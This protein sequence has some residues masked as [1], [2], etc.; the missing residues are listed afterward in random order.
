MN[1]EYTHRSNIHALL[2]QAQC[3]PV[4]MTRYKDLI[5]VKFQEGR[6][7]TAKGWQKVAMVDPG[8]PE[9]VVYVDERYLTGN[10]PLVLPID[11][12]P[13]YKTR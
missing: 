4:P 11:F 10:C 1:A 13:S 8:F 7:P 3:V 2:L 12:V 9:P 6:V 5:V